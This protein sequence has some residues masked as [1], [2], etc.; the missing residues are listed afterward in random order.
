MSA[1]KELY[2]I[3][4]EDNEK[5]KEKERKVSLLILGQKRTQLM[6]GARVG[7]NYVGTQRENRQRTH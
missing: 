3:E 7:K 5:E 6:D 4:F 1:P 2:Q